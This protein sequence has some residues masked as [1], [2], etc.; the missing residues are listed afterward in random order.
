[1]IEGEEA[2]TVLEIPVDQGQLLTTLSTIDTRICNDFNDTCSGGCPVNQKERGGEM[3]VNESIKSSDR[4]EV[5]QSVSESILLDVI[6][7]A[8][9]PTVMFQ[10]DC[11]PSN[12]STITSASASTSTSTPALT[13]ASP[14]SPVPA[15]TSTSAAT[16]A[17]APAPFE[18]CKAIPAA[19][20]PNASDIVTEAREHIIGSRRNTATREPPHPIQS[21]ISYNK[22]LEPVHTSANSRAVRSSAVDVVSHESYSAGST[23]QYSPPVTR[24]QS[25]L[26]FGI[27]AHPDDVVWGS[28]AWSEPP[29]EVGRPMSG[30][31]LL[32]R[33][34]EVP[35]T[36]G[37]TSCAITH[38]AS[39]AHDSIIF[40][41][42]GSDFTSMVRVQLT[43]HALTPTPTPAPAP[44]L[45]TSSPYPAL[46]CDPVL[47]PG[48]YESSSRFPAHDS[49][50]ATIGS[51]GEF[52][53]VGE[54]ERDGVG[55]TAMWD[56]DEVQPVDAIEQREWKASS[57]SFVPRTRSKVRSAPTCQISP[58]AHSGYIR[59]GKLLRGKGK[60]KALSATSDNNAWTYAEQECEDGDGVESSVDIPLSLPYHNIGRKSSTVPADTHTR[61]GVYSA[62]S[63]P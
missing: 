57:G 15:S 22:S 28:D 29:F 3:I 10:K 16:S 31:T 14:P 8:E 20:S 5:N 11:V 54:I 34:G 13:P 44:L 50:T 36:E 30:I 61:R 46:V 4:T 35:T 2:K 58:S 49:I 53:E 40:D 25:P 41:D 45:T 6:R 63:I 26:P 33:A 51:D 12:M 48:A 27:F 24:N 18:P 32:E 55:T 52:L 37:Y 42:G 47:A 62:V 56:G 21:D 39:S 38:G 1:L 7:V 43:G 59:D 19:A 60:G 23:S 17:P 9:D